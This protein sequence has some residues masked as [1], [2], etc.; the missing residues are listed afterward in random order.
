[1]KTLVVGLV[2]FSIPGFRIAPSPRK[3]ATPVVAQARHGGRWYLA[4]TGHAVYCRG[5]V[6]TIAMGDGTLR[7]VAT[8]CQGDRPLVPV[9][10]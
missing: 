9:K 10:D 2:L 6:I 4:E 1:M 3:P 7:R 8:Y 5:P